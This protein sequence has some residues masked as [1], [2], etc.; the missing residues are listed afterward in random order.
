MSTEL[1][2]CI[3]LMSVV[4]GLFVWS[5]IVDIQINRLKDYLSE[6]VDKVP[7]KGLQER[8][9]KAIY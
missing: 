9:R 8:I 4:L 3:V 7:D 1:T 5:V 6:R 2:V